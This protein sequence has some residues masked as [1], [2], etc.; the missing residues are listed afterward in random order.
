MADT[1]VNRTLMET[2][3][4]LVVRSEIQS[5]GTGSTDAILVDKSTFTGPN[6]LEP[7]RLVIEEIQWTADGMQVLLEFDHTADDLICSING[8]TSNSGEL[9]FCEDGKFQGFV[10]PASAGTTG[11]IVA[12]TVGHTAGDKVS[13]V[14]FLRKKD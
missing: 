13:M 2:K 6:G 9:D 7:G 1:V 5:D 4:R 3:R 14:L 12:T 10:D 11:D 8:N